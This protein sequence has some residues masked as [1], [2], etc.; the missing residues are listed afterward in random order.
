M[1]QG[2]NMTKVKG[3]RTGIS[4]VEMLIAIVL[5]GV[6]ATVS[7]IYY[8]NYYDTAFA[9]KKLEIS[10][11]IDQAS[12]LSNGFDMYKIE[13]GTAP[14]AI[15]DI[16]DARILTEIPVSIP[17]ITTS[18]WA[19]DAA[20]EVDGGATGTNDTVFVMEIDT[21]ATSA[22]DKLDYCNILNSKAEVTWDLDPAVSTLALLSDTATL[23]A[24]GIASTAD[25]MEYFHCSSDDAGTTMQIVFVKIVDPL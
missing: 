22:A 18:G 7:F 24:A 16:V 2:R 6:I 13:K 4:L 23:Y 5:F 12:Q 14:A 17:S 15:S 11:V 25:N 21:V 10:V 8:K 3:M 20:Y 19:I 9:A 1:I